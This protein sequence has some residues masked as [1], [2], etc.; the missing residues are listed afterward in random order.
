MSFHGTKESP[1]PSC[2]L[3]LVHVYSLALIQFAKMELVIIKEIN[4][5]RYCLTSVAIN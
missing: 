4:Q 2:E 1:P 5:K 3:P